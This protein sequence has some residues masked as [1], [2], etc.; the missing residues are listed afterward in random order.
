MTASWATSW[1]VFSGFETTVTNFCALSTRR[2]YPDYSW[3]SVGPE[4][5]AV[6]AGLSDR[7]RGV[8]G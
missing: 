2:W 8:V 7:V 5:G 1:N 6:Y 3:T 4:M